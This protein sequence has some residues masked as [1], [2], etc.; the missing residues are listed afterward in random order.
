[1]GRRHP[2]LRDD[3]EFTL[4]TILDPVN[5]VNTT[6]YRD[7]IEFDVG[8]K[9]F[10]Y[11]LEVPTIQYQLLFDVVLPK[12]DIEGTSFSEDWNDTTWVSGGPF[13][14]EEWA[15]G[16]VIRF[17]R[18]DRYWKTDPETNQ[19]L[20]YL[21]EIQMRV[22]GSSESSIDLF[23]DR[24]VD[25][26]EPSTSVGT[27]EELLEI[28][29]P[30]VVLGTV[31]GPVWEQLGFQFGP[32]RFERNPDSASALLQYRQAVAHAIDKERLVDR[33]LPGQLQ[34]LDSFVDVFVPGISAQAWGQYEYNP[35]KAR[36]LIDEVKELTGL[37]RVSAVLTGT[38]GSETRAVM[39]SVLAEMLG[40]V[41]I[42][43]QVLLE[44]DDTFIGQTLPQG[45]WD[46]GVWAWGTRGAG[47]ASLISIWDV[48]DP[49]QAPPRG[50]N[51][52]QW[53]SESS[54][55]QDEFSE[56][57]AEIRDAINGTVDLDAITI[58][59]AEAEQLLGVPGQDVGDSPWIGEDLRVEW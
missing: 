25:I 35:E 1:M 17:S 51:H 41:G 49:E 50:Q 36:L 20:P 32:G 52:Y 34:P 46:L 15:R 27:F 42:D 56:R 38:V 37:D 18:N 24:E 45:G 43:L 59:M 5:N 55:V 6:I 7:I 31:V 3:F 21:D 57:Y 12:H 29:D 48:F 8:A 30:D 16:E 9:T 47:V 26:I 39:A 58:V 28:D 4:E 54:A 40:D 44:D 10:E 53:G 11:T 22:R 2:D 13:V 33:I 19:V 14:L 23:I